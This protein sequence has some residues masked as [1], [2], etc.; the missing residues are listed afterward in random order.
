MRHETHWHRELKAKARIWLR[1]KGYTMIMEE[2]IIENL[3]IDVVGIDPSDLDAIGIECGGLNQ[4]PG[5]YRRLPIKIL[6]MA[7]RDGVYPEDYP[8]Q[9]GSCAYCM[10]E[11]KWKEKVPCV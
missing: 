6:H 4:P 2:E 8:H 11:Y 10:G 9:L 3:T 7:L 5:V 1:S